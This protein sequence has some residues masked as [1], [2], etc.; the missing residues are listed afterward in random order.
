MLTQ[1]EGE[2][3]VTG[4]DRGCDVISDGG[5]GRIKKFDGQGQKMIYSITFSPLFGL[6]R[7]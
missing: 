3:V 1:K 4:Q 2:E 5:S 6:Y 7:V